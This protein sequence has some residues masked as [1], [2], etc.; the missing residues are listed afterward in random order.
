MLIQ[1]LSYLVAE[2]TTSRCGLIPYDQS[3]CDEPNLPDDEWKDVVKA[4]AIKTEKNS[5]HTDNW[6]DSD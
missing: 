1:V 6:S 4:N 2:G 5:L 3:A